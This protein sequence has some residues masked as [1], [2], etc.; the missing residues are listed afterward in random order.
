LNF[1]FLS[2]IFCFRTFSFKSAYPVEN[3]WEGIIGFR[4]KKQHKKEFLYL[5]F[6]HDTLIQFYVLLIDEGQ[7]FLARL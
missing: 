2:F 7:Y 4:E 6:V 1:S 5:G 3:N